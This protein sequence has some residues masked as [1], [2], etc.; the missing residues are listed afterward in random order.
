MVG[1]LNQRAFTVY[2]TFGDKR[3]ISRA[4]VLHLYY[5]YFTL[6]GDLHICG[7]V[8]WLGRWRSLPHRLRMPATVPA[9]RLV[10]DYV[11]P[12]PW[13]SFVLCAHFA[14][15]L[16]YRGCGACRSSLRCVLNGVARSAA[17]HRAAQHP[18]F[19]LTS[20]MVAC[21][22][23]SLSTS[24]ATLLFCTSLSKQPYYVLRYMPAAVVWFWLRIPRLVCADTGQTDDGRCVAGWFGSH[25]TPHTTAFAP[26]ARAVCAGLPRAGAS[27]QHF[28]P[29]LLP[30]ERRRGGGA[31]CVVI[32]NQRCLNQTACWR[33]EAP[34]KCY[35]CSAVSSASRCCYT[36]VYYPTWAF[37]AL[38]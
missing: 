36:D 29:T 31:S 38:Y 17:T 25:T 5:C 21:T 33:E 28:C 16:C 23:L 12:S 35:S 22:T 8:V 30:L 27:D 3:G 4:V 13:T 2:Q 15:C 9:P 24:W 14:F 20:L 10:L 6:S 26:V 19:S 34:W 32:M 11:Y 37:I 18:H 1:S 7:Q